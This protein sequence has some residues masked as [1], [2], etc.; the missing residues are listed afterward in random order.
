[1]TILPGRAPIRWQIRDVQPGRS[2]TIE[3]PLDRAT[4]FFEWRFDAVSDRR[5]KLSQ[6]LVLSGDNAAA[7]AAQVQALFGPTLLDGM[8]R[9]ATDMAMAEAATK[10]DEPSGLT[11]VEEG[12]LRVL[13]GSPDHAIL[14][15]AKDAGRLV[16]ACFSARVRALLLY[17]AN[18]P[19]AFFDLSSGDAGA[20]LQKLRDYRIRLAVVCVPGSVRFSSRFG[21]M[22]AEENRG[23]H[24]R[25]F[26]SRDEAR[27]WL[28]R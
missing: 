21:E 27:S 18:L 15:R 3:M 16:E 4:L 5:T 2:F 11:V 23:P 25:I 26:E 13:E 19:D 10:T 6:H 9:I 7:H 14:G 8:N 20:L 12:G 24:F 17:P 28:R 22:V 1:M